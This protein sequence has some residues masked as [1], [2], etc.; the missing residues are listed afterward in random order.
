MKKEMKK[1]CE[2]K[3]DMMAGKG[4]KHMMPMPKGG[5][6]KQKKGGK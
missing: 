5:K 4:K 3:M 2:P 6:G 1:A